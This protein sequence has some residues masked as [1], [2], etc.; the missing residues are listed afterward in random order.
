[1]GELLYLPAD[2]KFQKDC[3]MKKDFKAHLRDLEIGGWIQRLCT[4]ELY[5][6]HKVINFICKFFSYGCRHAVCVCVCVAA[7]VALGKLV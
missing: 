6:V 2:L 3:A 4:I 1:M 7:A 5:H